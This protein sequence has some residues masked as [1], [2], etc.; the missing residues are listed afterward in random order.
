MADCAYC[1][2]AAAKAGLVYEDGALV[3]LMHPRPASP[4]HMVVLPKEHVPVFE[5]LPSPVAAKLFGL[6]N[7][8]SGVAFEALPGLGGTNM[9]IQSGPAAGQE[10]AHAAIQVIPRREGDGLAFEPPRRQ[11]PEEAMTAIEEGLRSTAESLAK[12]P[13]PVREAPRTDAKPVEKPAEKKERQPAGDEHSWVK[14]QLRR[15]P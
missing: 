5:L 11:L 13:E 14:R 8:L 6:A 10:V 1:A 12:E 4:G 15:R 2:L 3:A 7:R 9:V